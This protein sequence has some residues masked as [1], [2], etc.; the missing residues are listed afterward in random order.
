MSLRA[1]LLSLKI[2]F[3]GVTESVSARLRAGEDLFNDKLSLI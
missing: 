2:I 1:G 3:L